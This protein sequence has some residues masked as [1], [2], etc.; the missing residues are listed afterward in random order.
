MRRKHAEQA[1]KRLLRTDRA[2]PDNLIIASKLPL[3]WV[4]HCDAAALVF[5]SCARWLSG[6]VS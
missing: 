5:L 1:L 2:L 4:I 3:G 6:V